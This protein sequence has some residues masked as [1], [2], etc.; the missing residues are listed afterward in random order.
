MAD[1]KIRPEI[2]YRTNAVKR[3]RWKPEPRGRKRRIREPPEAW[4]IHACWPWLA[5]E[6]SRLDPR[7]VVTLGATAGRAPLGGSF[8]VTSQRGTEIC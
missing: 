3:F 1:A 2:T 6:L 7:V 4:Q 5:A 8:R